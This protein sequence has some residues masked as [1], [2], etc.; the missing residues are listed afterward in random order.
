MLQATNR[1]QATDRESETVGQLVSDLTQNF[2][3][4]VRDEI[5][6]ASKELQDKVA[7]LRSG[8]ITVG[9]GGLIA[10]LG[11]MSLCAAAIVGLGLI[12]GVATA[13]LVIGAF[14]ALIGG[15]TF[16]MGLGRLKADRLKPADTIRSLEEDVRWLKR[17]P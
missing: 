4:L 15:V 13:A 17:L 8:S 14:L 16:V 12:I 11:L 5:E 1:A 6:L 10:M 9:V 7:V 2:S 3:A